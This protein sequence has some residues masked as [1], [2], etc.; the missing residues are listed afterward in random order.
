MNVSNNNEKKM[1]NLERKL[2]YSLLLYGNKNLN[3]KKDR[4]SERKTNQISS[5]LFITLK[6]NYF[7]KN[8]VI[9]KQNKN[10][11]FHF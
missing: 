2:I 6:Y 5:F 8:N 10:S 1:L 7:V 11:R 9:F 4:N 3:E